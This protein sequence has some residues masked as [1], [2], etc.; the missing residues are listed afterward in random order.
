MEDKYNNLLDRL[1]ERAVAKYMEDMFQTSAIGDTGWLTITGED[2]LGDE[3]SGNV[4]SIRVHKTLDVD[5]CRANDVTVYDPEWFSMLVRELMYRYMEN[6]AGAA[7]L[8]QVP[9]LTVRKCAF[10]L[11]VIADG[12]YKEAA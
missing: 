1:V 6:I 9:R 10:L 5:M 11:D 4:R 8:V 12:K 7:A 3:P 2:H